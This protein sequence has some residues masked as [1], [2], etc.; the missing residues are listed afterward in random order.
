VAI[1]MSDGT[2]FQ[3]DALGEVPKTFQVD[4]WG[5]E[6]RSTHEITDNFTAF[7]R[8]LWHFVEMIR[9]GTPPIDPAET[10]RMMQTIRAGRRALA[11]DRPVALD[12]LAHVEASR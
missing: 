7:R 4:I 8:T 9:T 12:E 6:K 11:A 5:S 1:T 2:L 3:L 10:L